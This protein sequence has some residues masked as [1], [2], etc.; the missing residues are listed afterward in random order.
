MCKLGIGK[1]FLDGTQKE[2]TILK[3]DSLG[4]IK[5][6]SVKKSL[7]KLHDK[8][9]NHISE[10]GLISRIYK[11]HLQFNNET[12]NQIL[13]WANNLNRDFTKDIRIAKK[14]MR[15]YP[16]SFVIKETEI[17]TQ[18]EITSH[19]LEWQKCKSWIITSVGKDMEQLD[20]LSFA[21]CKCKMVQ[22][23]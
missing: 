18:R 22:S 8:L 17:K 10:K 13:K 20:L 4:L 11:L 12:R 14:H 2:F 16:P 5:F 9:A 1:H 23:L 15:M 7:R 21:F 6:C 3:N 19:S